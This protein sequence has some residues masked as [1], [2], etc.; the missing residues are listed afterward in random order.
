[1][2]TNSLMTMF[3]EGDANSS[4]SMMRVIV[5]MLVAFVIA[6]KFYNS[7]LTKQPIAIDAQDLT[8]LGAALGSKL[9]QNTQ[10]KTPDAPAAK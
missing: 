7:W 1:M 2:N 8:I 10:E 9:I 4:T 6:M 5:F 3:K